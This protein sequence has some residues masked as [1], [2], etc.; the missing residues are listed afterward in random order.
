MPGGDYCTREGFISRGQ[1]D[2]VTKKEGKGAV[3]MC[4]LNWIELNEQRG[5]PIHKER[6]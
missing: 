5:D 4:E 2:S 6:D 3:G 1:T